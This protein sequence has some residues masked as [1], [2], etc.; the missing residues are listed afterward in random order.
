MSAALTGFLLAD[1]SVG[2]R[3]DWMGELMVVYL[4]ERTDDSLVLYLAALMAVYLVASK[5]V[6]LVPWMD[7]M[8]V[9]WKDASMAVS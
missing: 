2:L 1:C 5:D 8:W 4:V 7:V 3:V 6:Q 9:V